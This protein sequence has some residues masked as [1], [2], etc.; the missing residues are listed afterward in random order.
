LFNISQDHGITMIERRT[1][2]LAI[3]LGS[4]ATLA[5]QTGGNPTGGNPT[6]P[7]PQAWRQVIAT[8]QGRSIT[9]KELDDYIKDGL[10]ARATGGNEQ[11]TYEI[12]SQSV[13][14]MLNEIALTDAAIAA[15]LPNSTFLE[16]QVDALGPA[17]ENETAPLIAEINKAKLDGIPM[18]AEGIDERIQMLVKQLRVPMVYRN[19]RQKADVIVLLDPPRSQVEAI[20]P[21]RGPDNAPVTLVAF[22]NFQCPT[23]QRGEPA[24]RKILDQYPDQL[25]LV[26]R[27][28]PRGAL[29]RSRPASEA[30]ICAG[31]QE[32][33][34]PYHDRLFENRVG[35]LSD[36]DLDD[37]GIELG[38]EMGRFRE[39]LSK[40]ESKPVIDAD[41]AAAAFH[42]LTR[43]PTY[44][45]NGIRI[46]G[47][48]N[49]TALSEMIDAE[50]AR[51]ASEA[52]KASGS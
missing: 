12:R 51:L 27:H 43:A 13:Q 32:K 52:A 17:S 31:A 6:E 1:R 35:G 48:R 23:C 14:A 21:S 15:G 30:A 11:T 19:L 4:I 44:F 46:T 7:A 42:G 8:I 45:L 2:Y 28:F 5:C 22:S 9:L 37:Y 38:L 20:G 50:L 34:W 26:F 39:C 49:A 24:M 36:Q 10:F 18:M 33:F 3:T 47:A 41:A 40:H 29:P 25:R 16:Q